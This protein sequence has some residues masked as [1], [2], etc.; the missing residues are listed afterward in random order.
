MLQRFT[1][2][3]LFLITSCANP[4]LTVAF[5][6]KNVRKTTARLPIDDMYLPHDRI[7]AMLDEGMTSLK[8]THLKKGRTRA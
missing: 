6:S 8:A 3:I 4:H 5:S 1:V 2:P 7:Y